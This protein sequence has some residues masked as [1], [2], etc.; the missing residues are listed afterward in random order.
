VTKILTV[1]PID[2]S[3]GVKKLLHFLIGEL[4]FCY[5]AENNYFI[6]RF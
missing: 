2:L 3:H 5:S 1:D 6:S 4:S